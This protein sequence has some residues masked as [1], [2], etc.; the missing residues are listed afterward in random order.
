MGEPVH[1]VAD[2]LDVG[3]L[4]GHAAAYDVDELVLAGADLLALGHH[5]LQRGGGRQDGGD[6]L[7]A[8]RA[9]VDA[10]VGGEGVAPAGA[11]RTRRTP[12]PAGPPHLCADPAAAA[13]PSGAGAGPARRRR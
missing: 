3:D 5:G 11:L 8:G 10:V 2:D 9:L 13:Q 6:V 12:T 4:R 7:E 1:G